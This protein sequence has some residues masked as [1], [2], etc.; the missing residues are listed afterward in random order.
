MVRHGK[1]P[2]LECSSR[3]DRRFSAFYARVRGKRIEQWYQE[4]KVF[5]PGVDLTWRERK[6]CRP[7]NPEECARLYANLWDEY[8]ALNPHLIDVLLAAPGLS[9]MFGTP[10]SVCQATELWRIRNEHMAG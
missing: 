8:A 4:A 3:G 7:L 10:G 9:D 5:E 6:G 2:Y 1:P